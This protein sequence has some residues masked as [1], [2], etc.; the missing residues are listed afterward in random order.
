MVSTIK[1]ER[2]EILE[3]AAYHLDL[4]A[5][6]LYIHLD[7]PEPETF[8]AL[9]AHPKVRVFAC[10]DGY[11]RKLGT[12][13]PDKHQAR[14][15]ANATRIYRQKAEV[16]WLIHIDVDEFLWPEGRV[17]DSL[18]ALPAEVGCARVRPVEALAGDGHHFKGFIP[19]GPDRDAT[20]ER[21]YPR[22]GPYVKGGFLSHLAG[23]LFLRTGLGAVTVKIH[24][25]FLDGQM[26]P[27]ET[28]L[29]DMLL[30]H[31]HAKSWEQWIGAFRYRLEHGS[32]RAELAPARPRE[33]GGMTIHE[34]LSLIHEAEGEAGL[35]SFY[36]ELC[37]DSPELRAALKAEGLLHK[38]D[39][40]LAERMGKQF[41]PN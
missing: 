40:Q 30:L 36:D 2:A 28:E 41:N 38:C 31:R 34:V 37:A 33:R 8:A 3:F 7:A 29:A 35:R 39:L 26:N 13:R 9:K 6:R 20:V 25:A 4:G 21:I 19:A 24:N 14:Q 12:R 32:Y 16:D 23:K 11:W 1:A 15:T 27:G 5:H 22:F 10:D 17:A 18:A